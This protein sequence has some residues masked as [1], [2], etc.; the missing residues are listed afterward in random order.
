MIGSLECDFGIAFL[1]LTWNFSSVELQEKQLGVRKHDNSIPLYQ[2]QVEKK[3]R[4]GIQIAITSNKK[5]IEVNL[6]LLLWF[7]E[8]ERIV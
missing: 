3:R 4:R 1:P 8:F 5:S 6:D 7:K 2:K